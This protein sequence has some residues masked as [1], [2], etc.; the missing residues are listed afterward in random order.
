M[1]IS[2]PIADPHHACSHDDGQLDGLAAK[3]FKP[4]G[5]DGVYGRTGAYENVVEALAAL[6]SSHRPAEAE[7]F[8][9]APVMSRASLEK[10]GYLKSFPNLVGCV[11]TLEGTDREIMKSAN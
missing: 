11:S 1:N 3:I 6:I 9:F 8:R 4:S 7:V 2:T 5:V 10:Q